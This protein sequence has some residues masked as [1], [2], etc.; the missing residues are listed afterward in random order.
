MRMER[1]L[2]SAM[3]TYLD[4]LADKKDAPGGGSASALAGALGAA[5]G[6]MV[7]QFTLGKKKY[8]DVEGDILILLGRFEDHRNT[9]TDLMQEDV[10]VFHTQMAGAYVLPNETDEQKRIR[11][12]AIENACKACC[13]PPLKVMRRCA[14]IMTDLSELA[15]IGTVQLVS[16]VGVGAAMAMGAFEG[17]RFNVEINI[18]F[19][20]DTLFNQSVR[21]EVDS[22]SQTVP[23]A[24]ASILEKV[25]EKIQGK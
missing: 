5:L 9:L 18:K 12:E 14:Q 6:S 20:A 8:A 1:Y 10:D 25:R 15:D 11:R 16:D 13:Q 23:A 24:K 17:A 22:L 21:K 2:E 19:I 3:K 4:D 7:C